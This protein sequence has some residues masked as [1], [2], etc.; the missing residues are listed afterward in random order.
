MPD[1]RRR[2]PRRFP[3]FRPDDPVVQLIWRATEADAATLASLNALAADTAYVGHSASLTRCQ[4]RTDG[5]KPSPQGARRRVYRGRLAELERNYRAGRRPAPGEAVAPQP[6]A[7]AAPPRSV[8]SDNWLVLEHVG[9]DRAMPDLRA[10]ALVAKALRNTLMSGYR[11]SGQETAIP[12][13]VSGHAPGGAPTTAP[14]A[15]IVPMAFVDH[16]YGDGHVLGFA[17]VPPGEGGLLDDPAFQ[18]AVR[19]VAQWKEEE[20][21]RELTV[22]LMVGDRKNSVV[23]TPSG[24]SGRRSL[25]PAPYIATARR[26]ATCTPIALDRHATSKKNAEREAEIAAMIAQACTHI[27]LPPPTLIA[28]GKHST[29]AGAVPPAYPSGRAPH[30][31]RWRM[32]QSLAGRHLTHAVI[33]F[34]KKV[35]G[36]V[37]LGAGRF[38]G[39]GLC[40]ALDDGRA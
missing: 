37:I 7:E 13:A 27:G 33:E 35:R 20:E 12:A 14:H 17:V 11:R 23:L 16:R 36:P 25:D 8:F 34:E 39:L 15:A 28:A 4:F 22:E 19:A 24:E 31:M 40:R 38:C 6:D 26:W 32:P 21:R 30:W 29:F 10:S 5:E 18:D 9:D 1:L 2:Q 3:A